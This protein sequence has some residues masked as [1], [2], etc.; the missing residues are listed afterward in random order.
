MS[1]VVAAFLLGAFLI[2]GCTAPPRPRAH[3]P[4]P[5]PARETSTTTRS[6]TITTG[7]LGPAPGSKGKARVW[8]LTLQVL[9]H[10]EAVPTDRE[11][12]SGSVVYALSAKGLAPTVATPGVDVVRTMVFTSAAK[13]SRDLASGL[14]PTGV[15]AV[16]YDN[17]DWSLTPPS[18]RANP[19]VAYEEAARLAHE[20]GL[21]VVATPGWLPG[22]RGVPTPGVV[23]R[24]S[25][26][27][28]L[29]AIAPDV[30]VVDIQAQELRF[31][32]S[33]SAYLAWVAPL[34]E[35]VRKAKSSVVV[36]SGLSTNPL[37][38]L[39]SASQ[40]LA[41]ARASEGVVRGWW[42][43]VPPP[44]PHRAGPPRYGVAEAFVSALGPG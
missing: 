16:L 2:A 34:A 17:E 6:G 22:Y 29:P 42:L 20:H 23:A 41:V 14:I 1:S 38:G 25:V 18:E 39:A 33:P 26:T 11:A 28:I 31:E 21:F 24:P 7:D 5:G 35:A 40:L 37:G 15:R 4:A 27:A 3:R 8:L 44:G 32:S 19:V 13:L 36:V 9:D 30:D 12:L 43:N 10:L